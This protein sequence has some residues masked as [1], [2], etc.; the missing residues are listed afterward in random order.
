MDIDPTPVVEESQPSQG[1][2]VSQVSEDAPDPTPTPLAVKRKAPPIIVE[3]EEEVNIMDRL[4]TNTIKFKRQ[5]LAEAEDRRARGETTPPKPAT[6]APPP[7]PAT[8]IV[9]KKPIPRGRKKVAAEENDKDKDLFS[10]IQLSREKEAEN[11]AALKEEAAGT[12]SEQISSLTLEQIKASVAIESMPVLSSRVN[13]RLARAA[14]ADESERWDEKW[15]GRKNFK[16]FRRVPGTNGGRVGGEKVIVRLEEAKKRDYGLGEGYWSGEG[17][18][19]TQAK[20]KSKS[21]KGKENGK[22]KLDSLLET[23]TATTRSQPRKQTIQKP[24]P[25]GQAAQKLRDMLS[26]DEEDDFDAH[27]NDSADDPFIA[28][29]PH[30]PTAVDSSDVEIVE[31]PAPAKGKTKSPPKKR[32][33]DREAVSVEP[34]TKKKK[35]LGIR[36]GRDESEDEDSEDEL[37]FKLK[38]RR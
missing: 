31:A 10:L 24:K 27:I 11:E 32:A 29:K 18:E 28:P 35:L 36:K 5:K 9:P 25:T 21:Q 3:E 19:D 30:Y 37:K 1:L 17:E 26:D 12:I 20:F 33:A 13:P 16:Q 2:F 4:A 15:N 8:T 23:Q 6:I 14:Q 34:P 7:K 38:K 22:Q